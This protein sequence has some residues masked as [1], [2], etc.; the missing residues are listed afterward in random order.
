MGFQHSVS[1]KI[2]GVFSSPL[3]FSQLSSID[4]FQGWDSEFE[5][6]IFV[7]L[8][9]VVDLVFPARNYFQKFEKNLCFQALN[10]ILTGCLL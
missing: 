9:S 5:K 4:E 1:S 8:R 7:V 3:R 10:L 6:R 2:S